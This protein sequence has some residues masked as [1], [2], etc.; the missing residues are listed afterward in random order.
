[1]VRIVVLSR[2]G[3]THPMSGGAGRYIHEIFRRL[4]TQHSVTILSGSVASRPSVENIDGVT[5]RNFPGAFHRVLLPIRYIA[6]FAGKVDL[7]VDNSDVGMPWLSP[8]YSRVPRIAIIHQLVREIFYDE[9]PRPLS[10]I[11]F[12]LEPW[13]YRLYSNSRIVAAS[14][15]TARDL[16]NCGMQSENIDVIEPGCTNLGFH[17]LALTERSSKTIACVSRL[18]KYKGLQFALKAFMKVIERS[19]DAKL[20]VAGYGPFHQQLSRMA[21]NLGLSGNVSFLGRISDDSKFKLYG[22]TRV[23]IY[24]SHREGFGISV[25]EANSV[26]TPVVGWNVPGSRD[27]IVDGT[28]GL[29]APFPDH[30]AFADR[31]TMLLNDDKTW[32]KLSDSAWQWAQEHSWDKSAKE[33]ERIIEST[34][35]TA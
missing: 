5:Y 16:L 17:R 14:R 10:D 31:I 35:G 24:P 11:G 21:N 22:E 34:L 18:M 20:V 28:T 33:F 3:I 25:M 23:A 32:N 15:S 13:M 9:L 19:P 26:G 2:R 1:M 6:K 7:L 29:L 8:I 27:A 30:E 12:A 4:S